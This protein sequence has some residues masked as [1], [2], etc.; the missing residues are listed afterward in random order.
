MKKLKTVLQNKQGSS[1]L[2]YS[3]AI[4]L[5]LCVL[6]LGIIV[7]MQFRNLSLELYRTAE[8][9]LEEY[10][11]LEAR[12]NIDSIKNGNSYILSLDKDEYISYLANT[13]KV[14]ENLKGKTANGRSFQ[15]SNLQIVFNESNKMN[16]KV[17]FDLTM[18]VVVS[19]IA[20]P[21]FE[22]TISIHSKLEAKF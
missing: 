18:P 17:Q 3:I 19:G 14:D 15:I 7:T 1:T 11:V 5:F 12:N 21:S 8:T 16:T 10:V 20:F 22:T 6:T 9:S 4:L 13:L 2:I